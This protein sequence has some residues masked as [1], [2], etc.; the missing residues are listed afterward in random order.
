MVTGQVLK[1]PVAA[2]IEEVGG[3][4]SGGH[5]F[6]SRTEPLSPELPMVLPSPVGE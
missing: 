2:P 5:L 1:L 4:K 3:D 6:P